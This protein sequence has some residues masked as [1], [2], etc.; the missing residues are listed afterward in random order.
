M[1]NSC[2]HLPSKKMCALIL[3]TFESHQVED[4][5]LKIFNI[6]QLSQQD[7]SLDEKQML[8]RCSLP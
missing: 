3:I 7:L 6:A 1:N 5:L 8:L 4:I 2:P